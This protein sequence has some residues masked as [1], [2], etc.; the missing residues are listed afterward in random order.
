MAL[1]QILKHPALKDWTGGFQGIAISPVP[2]PGFLR[3][4]SDQWLYIFCLLVMAVMF[5]IG[6]NLLRGRTGRAIVAIREHP[7]AAISMGINA[8]YYKSMTFGVSA[9]FA[10][11]G[12]ALG[13]FAAQFVSP[14]SFT[15][16]LSITLLVGIVVG[17][18]ASLSGAIF[19]AIF[20]QF[21]PNFAEKISSSAPWAIYG[22]VIIGCVYLLPRGA[23]GLLESLA[24][25]LANLW[26]RGRSSRDA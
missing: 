25:R 12:G 7:T 8:G 15:F 9:M 19:G 13:A 22:V 4:N 21:I 3:L 20:I 10:G 2:V 23:A 17:G 16:F 1:P 24:T 26:N 5:L 18:L 11:V 14:D 6:W